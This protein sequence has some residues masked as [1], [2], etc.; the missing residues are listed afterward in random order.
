MDQGGTGYQKEHHSKECLLQLAVQCSHIK[1][2]QPDDWY[3]RVPRSRRYGTRMRK[4]Y[5]THKN[6][7]DAAHGN[8]KQRLKPAAGVQ[9]RNFEDGMHPLADMPRIKRYGKPVW[10]RQPPRAFLNAPGTSP[11]PPFSISVSP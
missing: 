6:V 1:V 8:R 2:I 11:F 10:S 4:A 7:D 3:A 9:K 5:V